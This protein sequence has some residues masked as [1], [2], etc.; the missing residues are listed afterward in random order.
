ML[1]RSIGEL[2]PVLKSVFSRYGVPI[3]LHVREPLRE[4]PL[5]RC[6]ST[7]LQ[8]WR[9][10]WRREELLRFGRAAPI[11]RLQPVGDCCSP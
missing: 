7:L 10:D 4:N 11:L 3:W 6:V 9:L 1:V 2:A 8:V 5:V